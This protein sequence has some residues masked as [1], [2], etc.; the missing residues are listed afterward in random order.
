[1]KR[2]TSFTLTTLLAA[3][4]AAA[5]LSLSGCAKPDAPTDE[6]EHKDHDEAYRVE[7]TLARGLLQDGTFTALPSDAG[8]KRYN[9]NEQKVIF[10]NGPAGFGISSA[11]PAKQFVVIGG[12][13]ET[14]PAPADPASANWTDG[15]FDFAAVHSGEVT[16]RLSV[17]FYAKDGDEITSEFSSPEESKLHQLFFTPENIAAAF[18][19]EADAAAFRPDYT[20]LGYYYMDRFGG[21]FG[22]ISNPLGLEGYIEFYRALTTFDLRIRLMHAKVSKYLD[23]GVK[24]SPFYKPSPE[25][26]AREDWEDLDIKVPVA[27]FADAAE[28]PLHAKTFEEL[29]D[30]D[31][32]LVERLAE[33]LGIT[34]EEAFSDLLR[35]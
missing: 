26:L 10:E 21:I 8:A 9:A 1:M 20:F 33:T 24:T 16:Y 35:A 31:R 7:L 30:A 5:A 2:H 3:A 6:T 23:N 14:K 13:D 25:Q 34:P 29:T 15:T 32:R 18:G 19:S 4:F 22:G 11:S 28:L 27:V 17:R 12:I